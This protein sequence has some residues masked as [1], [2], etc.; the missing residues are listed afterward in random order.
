[1]SPIEALGR[2]VD[3]EIADVTAAATYYM[4]ETYFNFSRSLVESERPTD[5]KPAELEEFEMALD[6]EAFPFEEKAIGVHE[7]NMELLQAGVFNEW[8]EKSLGRLTELMPGR[9]AKHETS[10]GFLGATEKQVKADAPAAEAPD[11]SANEALTEDGPEPEPDRD[12]RTKCAPTTRRRCDA[13]GSAVRARHRPAAQGDRTG[14]RIDGSAHRSRHCVRARRRPGRA[15]ASLNKALE[16]NPHTLPPTTSSAWCSG[17]RES[18]RRRAPVTKRPWHSPPTFITRTG[19]LPFCATC[20]SGITTC[21]LEHYEAYSRI[22]PDDAEVV[23][24]IADLRNRGS[25]KE[26]R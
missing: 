17:A 2:L 18:L 21:A 15:E 23:K 8:T 11:P 26:K 12:P 19:T 1:M 5:L 24:W 9:Y 3:Y 10:S 16:S 20:I 14:A 13:G 7:K 6:E 4:A 25:R 22:V